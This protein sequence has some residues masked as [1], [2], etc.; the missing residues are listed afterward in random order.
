M[1]T[2]P[3]T[4]IIKEFCSRQDERILAITDDFQT[5]KCQRLASFVFNNIIFAGLFVS[6]GERKVTV[7]NHDTALVEEL[8]GS[9]AAA[10]LYLL[11]SEMQN[12]AQNALFSLYQSQFPS[13]RRLELV[14]K[15]AI[16]SWLGAPEDGFSRAGKVVP[17]YNYYD[18]HCDKANNEEYDFTVLLYLNKSSEYKGGQLVLLDD[19]IDRVIEPQCGRLLLFESSLQNIHRVERVEEGNRLVLSLWLGLKETEHGK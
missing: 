8:L 11:K 16:L 2:L 13:Y 7:S 19:H 1:V 9:R 12:H 17:T 6:N 18:P 3:T 10:L 4:R 5:G 14:E 15:G